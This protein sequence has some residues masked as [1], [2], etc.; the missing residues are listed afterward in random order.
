MKALS[1]RQ[2]A[3]DCLLG[4]KE[5]SQT[6]NL[7]GTALKD[8]TDLAR[9]RYGYQVPV[10]MSRIAYQRCVTDPS[11]RAIG[12]EARENLWLFKVLALAKY[13]IQHSE[14]GATLTEFTVPLNDHQR[15]PTTETLKALVYPGAG[16]APVLLIKH[17]SE[18]A[19]GGLD[20]VMHDLR[21]IACH[22]S[23]EA[24]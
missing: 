22:I 17:A 10:L 11:A 15:P 5:T 9:N 23:E 6:L 21:A 19:T 1:N 12:G 4:A 8:V 20:K 14:P 7:A 13:A 16:Q 3:I 24:V 2:R 18:V